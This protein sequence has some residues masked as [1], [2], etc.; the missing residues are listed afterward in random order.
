MNKLFLHSLQCQSFC[1]K[2]NPPFASFYKQDIILDGSFSSIYA[3]GS[4]KFSNISC[5]TGK[6]DVPHCIWQ[7]FGTSRTGNW[8]M[9]LQNCKACIYPYGIS[10]DMDEDSTLLFFCYRSIHKNEAI[11]LYHILDLDVF[12]KSSSIWA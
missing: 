7:F 2:S 6:P 5:H 9:H 12:H 3:Y 1:H 8:L 10:L 11:D 4:L